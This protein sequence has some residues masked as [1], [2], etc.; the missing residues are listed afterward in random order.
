MRLPGVLFSSLGGRF[1]CFAFFSFS[2]FHRPIKIRYDKQGEGGHDGE[3]KIGTS[4]ENDDQSTLPP[5]L[6]PCKRLYK[7]RSSDTHLVTSAAITA[8]CRL[9]KFLLFPSPTRLSSILILLVHDRTK[10]HKLKQKKRNRKT[11][12]GLLC[13]HTYL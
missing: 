12:K 6:T 7:N 11:F 13:L 3:H 10:G 4:V 9:C 2:S 8:D 5:L 1:S